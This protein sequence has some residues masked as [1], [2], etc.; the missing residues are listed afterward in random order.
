[1]DRCAIAYEY[2]KAGFNCAQS[3]VGAFEDLTGLTREQLMAMTGGFGGGVLFQQ[4]EAAGRLVGLPQ[5][6]DALRQLLF[7]QSF[8]HLRFRLAAGR[9]ALKCKYIVAGGVHPARPGA[10]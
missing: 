7:A 10:A 6:E 4:H 9:C 2:H 3:V 1:M 8:Q 5:S